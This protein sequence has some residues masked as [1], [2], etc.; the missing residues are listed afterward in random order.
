M[1][2]YEQ[3]HPMLACLRPAL[4]WPVLW[5]G[6]K[7][8]K[9]SPLN[10]FVA[11]RKLTFVCRHRLSSEKKPS[12][13]RLMPSAWKLETWAKN[14]SVRIWRCGSRSST[15][16]CGRTSY[17]C[18]VFFRCGIPLSGGLKVRMSLVVSV[19]VFHFSFVKVYTQIETVQCVTLSNN[20]LSWLYVWS[21]FSW[22]MKLRGSFILSYHVVLLNPYALS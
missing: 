14:S 5:P 2:R 10:W 20:R 6:L 8:V 11:T 7:V 19:N 18:T 22:L 12:K 9:V 4:R 3:V 1:L 16:S 13:R 15:W 17:F 21:D